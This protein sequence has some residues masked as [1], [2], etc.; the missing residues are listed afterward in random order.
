MSA[1]LHCGAA[2]GFGIADLA[3][4]L[5][6]PDGGPILTIWAYYDE[7]GEYAPGTGK[8]L[9][10][11]IGGCVSTLDKWKKFEPEWKAVLAAEGLSHFHM[12]DFERWKAPFDFTLA[13][14]TRDKEKHNRLL[15]N[16]LDVMAPYIEGYYGFS[17]WEIPDDPY[18]A[19]KAAMEQCTI[20]AISHAVKNLHTH[21][22]QSIHLVFAKQRHYPRVGRQYWQ[23]YYDRH[24]ARIAT[25][26]E[27][28]ANMLP[29]LQ[30]ADVAAYELA[31]RMRVDRPIRYPFKRIQ[32][33][34]SARGGRLTY[35][36]GPFSPIWR[37]A[38][39]GTRVP[40]QP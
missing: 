8:L 31:R 12:T 9:K 26:T 27:A 20:G 28:D 6:W 5:C 16:L 4:G 24:D 17:S 39:A 35:Q 30:A 32:Q 14:G 38:L 15:N 25:A 36:L 3:A 13:D 40:G 10:M 7:S 23:F 2:P 22:G 21:Y 19:H 37:R 18:K 11:T 29:Q 1:S 34:V 33:A